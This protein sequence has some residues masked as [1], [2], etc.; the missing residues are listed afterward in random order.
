MA[1][2]FKKNVA[3]QFISTATEEPEAPKQIQGEGLNIPIGYKLVKENKSVRLQL[4]IRPTTKETI[5]KLAEAQGISVNDLINKILDEYAERK[6][7]HDR[8]S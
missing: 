7:D 2:N 8:T 4:L 1:K 3:E 5:K 6:A